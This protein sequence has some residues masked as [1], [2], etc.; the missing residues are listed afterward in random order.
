MYVLY[1]SIKKIMSKQTQAQYVIIVQASPLSYKCA[2]NVTFVYNILKCVE[3]ASY[4]SKN[5]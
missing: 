1:T 5:E 3:K 4:T 2:R